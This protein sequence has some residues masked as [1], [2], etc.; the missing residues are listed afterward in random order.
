MCIKKVNYIVLGICIYCE[1]VIPKSIEGVIS[2][3]A[4]YRIGLLS[5][6]H[7]NDECVRE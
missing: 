7:H 4:Q 3:A 6:I 1:K 5:K 2:F